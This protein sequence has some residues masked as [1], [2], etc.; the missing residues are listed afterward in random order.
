VKLC[1]PARPLRQPL[2]A[3]SLCLLTAVA[4]ARQDPA[5]V[6]QA[7]EDYLRTQTAGLPGE[8]SFTAGGLDPANHLAPC[9]ALEVAMAPGARAWGRTHVVVRCSGEP[10]WSVF[11]PV[12]I[13]VVADYLVTAA[14]LSQGQTIDASHLAR[15]RGDYSDLPTGILSDESQA[16]G[17]T[18]SHSVPAGRPLRADMLRLPYVVLQNQSVRVVSR[19]A[20]FEVANEGRALTNGSEGQVV[21]VRLANGQIVSGVARPGGVVSIGF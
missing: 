12:H 1:R 20:G 10:R 9:H 15:Q 16:V 3:A 18:I 14:P 6:R 8:T 11:L 13:R 4:A 2:L 7:V 19:G 21:Q 5:V 17:R